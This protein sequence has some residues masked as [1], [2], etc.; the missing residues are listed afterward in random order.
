VLISQVTQRDPTKS[1]LTSL[2]NRQKSVIIRPLYN[3]LMNILGLSHC[4]QVGGLPP[5][6]KRLDFLNGYFEIFAKTI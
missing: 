5:I 6:S 4:W 3:E 1:G 2:V